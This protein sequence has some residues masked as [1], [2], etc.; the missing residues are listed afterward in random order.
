M[1][2]DRDLNSAA[3]SLGALVR[4]RRKEAGL[5]QAEL[6]KAAAVGRRFVSELEGGKPTVRLDRVLA[7]L[8]VF[9]QTLSLAPLS[10]ASLGDSRR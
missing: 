10:A 9:G 1:D 6:A 5:S 2:P 3:T 7:I 8:A 4:Q